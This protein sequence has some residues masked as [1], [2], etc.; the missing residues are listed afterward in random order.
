MVTRYIEDTPE[1][2]PQGRQATNHGTIGVC[3]VATDEQHIVQELC[4]MD[5]VAPLL[6][7]WMIEVD[8]R[9]RIDLGCV[10]RTV[11]VAIKSGSAPQ[12]GR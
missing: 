10:Q 5:T 2:C 11:H 8:V 6:V 1:L 9:H 4:C 7:G 12:S 3:K